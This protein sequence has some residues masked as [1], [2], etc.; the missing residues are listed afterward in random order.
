MKKILVV[1]L[2]LLSILL[3]CYACDRGGSSGGNTGNV[4]TE[5][6]GPVD[7]AIESKLYYPCDL[8]DSN[9]K[10]GATTVTGGFWEVLNDVEWLS[11]DIA[12]AGYVVLAFTVENNTGL[13]D[14][15]KK[16]HLGAIARLKTI[17]ADGQSKLRGK[18]DE[19]KLQTCGHS[20]G[21]GSALWAASI[22]GKGVKT[23]VGMA[24]W[25]E[26]AP[27]RNYGLEKITA[28]T[29]IQA[30][31]RDSMAVPSMTR[32]EYGNPI[33]S[34]SSNRDTGLSDNISRAYFEF[35]G[36]G[37]AAWYKAFPAV[38]DKLSSNIVAWMKYYL[39][40]DISY[41]SQ[42]ADGSECSVY[43]WVDKK[44]N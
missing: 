10:V 25:Q 29:L 43:E 39:D 32:Q 28:A 31:S 21:G 19:T 24:P 42:L 17:N 44:G 18:I 5:D 13:V 34:G 8:L 15:W 16:S 41:K 33:A 36:L 6:G 2:A 26:M 9:L 12:E 27:S 22:L 11:Q 20:K 38:G 3:C 37:H 1:M 4:C 14:G 35:E 40:G 30:A 7:G 23:A